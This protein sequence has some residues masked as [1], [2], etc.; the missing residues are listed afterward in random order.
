MLLPVRSQASAGPTIIGVEQTFQYQHMKSCS[1]SMERWLRL[2][3]G[4]WHWKDLTLARSLGFFQQQIVQPVLVSM[5]KENWE[6]VS[7]HVC[8]SVN[9]LR[10]RVFFCFFFRHLSFLLLNAVS[11]PAPEW[12]WLCKHCSWLVPELFK[13]GDISARLQPHSPV[14]FLFFAT[15]SSLLTY[16]VTEVTVAGGQKGWKQVLNFNLSRTP[17]R[18]SH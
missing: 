6:K 17:R 9:K 13:Y 5:C 16:S 15:V 14:Y 1:S 8:S 7:A 2:F 11:Q 12:P 3:Q 18:V 10:L 4:H